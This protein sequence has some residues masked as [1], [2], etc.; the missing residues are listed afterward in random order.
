MLPLSQKKVLE[1]GAKVLEKSWNFLLP[2]FW[3]PWI[4]SHGV[5]TDRNRRDFKPVEYVVA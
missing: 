2:D 4:A 1:N 3:E 5:V